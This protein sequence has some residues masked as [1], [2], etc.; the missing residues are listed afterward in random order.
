M[1][2]PALIFDNLTLGYDRHPVVHHLHGEIAEGALIALVG[3]NGAGK[4]TLLKSIAGELRPIEG[5]IRRRPGEGGRFAYLPQQTAL[6]PSFP[7]T[8]SDLVA[9]GL[10]RRLG[11][12]GGIGRA[13]RVRLADALAQVGLGGFERRP[14]GTLSGGQLQRA[15]FARLLL[16][17]A[18]LILLDEPYAAVD[19]QTV[20]DMSRLIQRWHDEGRTVIAVL[21]DLDHVRVEYPEALLLARETI[22]RGPAVEVLSGTNLA[23]AR[24]LAEAFDEHAPVCHRHAEAA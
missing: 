18:P 24:A 23:R 16:Q 13:G 11:L 5:G 21:H 9:M 19:A 22:A 10:W 6:D 2:Q 8:V 14:I 15:R 1:S 3:P 4:S 20:Q 7:I 17:D 12:F